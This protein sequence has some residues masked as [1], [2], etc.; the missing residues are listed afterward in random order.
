MYIAVMEQS[1]GPAVDCAHYTKR[2]KYANTHRRKWIRDFPVQ[3]LEIDVSDAD[4]V[5]KLKIRKRTLFTKSADTK[6]LKDEKL[7][8]SVSS[9]AVTYIKK[10][11]RVQLFLAFSYP[12]YGAERVLSSA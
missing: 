7:A 10:A 5:Q 6:A 2:T 12:R 3:L 9:M 4:T 11:N 8:G 1:Y